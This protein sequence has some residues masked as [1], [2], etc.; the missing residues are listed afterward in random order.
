MVFCRNNKCAPNFWPIVSFGNLRC[1]NSDVR[2]SSHWYGF[3]GQGLPVVTISSKYRVTYSRLQPTTTHIIAHLWIKFANYIDI[4][5]RYL[6]T[7][8]NLHH[9][10]ILFIIFSNELPAIYQQNTQIIPEI[11]S[12]NFQI[13]HISLYLLNFLGRA[14][15]LYGK[16]DFRGTRIHWSKCCT[17]CT[18]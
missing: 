9:V 6:A 2:Q 18:H 17:T 11:I 3:I 12:T 4:N 8:N 5:S 16:F 10:N 15:A 13:S 7:N 14:W 1:T